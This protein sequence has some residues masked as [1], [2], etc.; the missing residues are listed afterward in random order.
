MSLNN[1]NIQQVTYAPGD[2]ILREG[3]MCDSLLVVKSGQIEVFRFDKARKKIPLALVNS[4]EYLGEMSLVADRPHSANA[5]ALTETVC[6]KI[7]ND[8]LEAQMRT[9]PTWLVALTRG[10]VMK[11]H[12]TN[13]LLKRNGI[14]DESLYGAVKAIE[15]KR[16]IAE[17]KEQKRIEREEKKAS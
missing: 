16:A 9:A 11:L 13:D 7:S 10:L 15:T 6:L 3:A 17:E 2:Y 1:N 12:K 8:A 5:V 14:V 4:G